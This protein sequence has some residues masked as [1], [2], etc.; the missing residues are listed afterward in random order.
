MSNVE[1]W[2]IK[3]FLREKQDF[4]RRFLKKIS[5]AKEMTDVRTVRPA[6]A[7]GP[8]RA[9]T[10]PEN[11]DATFNLYMIRKVIIAAVHAMKRSKKRVATVTN[12]WIT[13]TAYSV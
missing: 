2:I 12:A 8:H 5:R 1:I 10:D 6:G 11:G 9:I 4:V 3:V 7:P 13:L